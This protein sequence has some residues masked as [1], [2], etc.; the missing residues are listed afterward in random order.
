MA[1]SQVGSQPSSS[2]GQ[3]SPIGQAT[4]LHY[5]EL[6]NHDCMTTQLTLDLQ[7][8][9]SLL[10]HSF[11]H[12]RWI[13]LPADEET[14]LLTKHRDVA[15][16]VCTARE[17]HPSFL[18]LPSFSFR[19]IPCPPIPPIPSMPCYPACI[20]SHAHTNSPHEPINRPVSRHTLHSDGCKL[21]ELKLRTERK[22]S[23]K[24]R[25]GLEEHT[26]RGKN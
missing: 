6:G 18:P 25:A 24:G 15:R 11:S 8:L 21:S 20:Q 16:I 5:G 3:W 12:N 17:C 9:P 19:P 10:S 26:C 2:L 4:K 13:R 7:K 14:G 22:Q 1:Q 23:E